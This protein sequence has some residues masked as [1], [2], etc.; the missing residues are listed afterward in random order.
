MRASKRRLIK[1]GIQYDNLFPG[2]SGED[3]VIQ[4]EGKAKLH[5]TLNLVK[6]IVNDT[7]KD[8]Q[9]IAK[10]LKRKDLYSTCEATWNFVYDHIQYAKD[11]AG[12]EQVRRPSRTWKDRESGVDC[13]CYTV[14]ISSILTNLKIPH[15]LRITK[16]NGKSHFQHIYPIVPDKDGGYITI[17][18]VTDQFD[19]EVP[20]SGVKDF[21]ASNKSYISEIKE[22]N[23]ISGVDFKAIS[24]DGNVN[25]FITAIVVG[26]ASPITQFINHLTEFII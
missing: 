5:H 16:Y 24:N 26:I 10:V 4:S 9:L 11:K 13:D 23:E 15:R 3:I 18:C 14:F 17:D 8:T 2:S 7:L 20:F 12:V 22:T 6:R 21:D 1:S 19:F 25:P